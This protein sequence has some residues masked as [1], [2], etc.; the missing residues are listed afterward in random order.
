MSDRISQS[1]TATGA[2]AGVSGLVAPSTK[3]QFGDY[4]ANGCMAAAKKMKT[5]PRAFA[6]KVLASL[7]LSDVAEKVEL[8]GPGFINIFLKDDYITTQLTSAADDDYLGVE[9]LQTAQKV[10]VDYSGPNLAK[11]MHVGHLRSTI[12][13]DALAR[14]LAFKGCEVTRQNHVGDWGTQFGMLLAY[15][16]EIGEVGESLA[17]LEEF[18]RKSKSRF[19]EDPAFADKSRETVVKLQGGDEKCL[20]YWQAFLAES[21]EH[22]QS[23]YMALGVLLV[24][25]DVRGESSYNDDLPNVI[26]DLK[27]AGLLEE[28]DG[29]MGVFLDE[30]RNT[31]DERAFV[32]IRKSDGGYLYATTDLA[33][34]RY[35]TQTLKAD[36][37]LYVTDSRQAQHFAQVFTIAKNPDVKFAGDAVSLEHVPFGMMLGI[38]GR[39]FKTRTGGTVKL[40]DLLKEAQEKAEKLVAEKNPDLDESQ[41]H[42]IASVVGIGALKYA[43]LAQNRTSD[44][45]FAWNKMLSM[46]G[47]TAPYM[48]YAYARI[49]SIFRK[50]A[51]TGTNCSGEFR[52][53]EPAE[54]A[55]GVK[56][57]QFSE[58][59]ELV[60][61]NCL[62]SMLCTYLYELSGAFMSFYESCPVLKADDK[63]RTSR[64][65]LCDLTARIIKQGLE[66]LG[67]ETIEKM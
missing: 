2:P 57:L 17:D 40:M 46:E 11:E 28:S 26:A 47:N 25:A 32:I 56:L 29:A 59:I 51:D 3:P 60:A 18:Y 24:P 22:C 67:I 13:G 38:D 53:A 52:L 36:R 21:L 30:F 54:R 37:I 14:I 16:E 23:V 33:A 9:T 41:R 65:T 5:N 27:S 12:I 15:M 39:P 4:Q 45:V 1:I 58:T 7:D 66:L 62:P 35:R 42:E 63:T 49:R 31:D 55:L 43:D 10:V 8:A 64:L 48:Q 20:A 6:E 19:D 34:I 44:Y 61:E 50:A